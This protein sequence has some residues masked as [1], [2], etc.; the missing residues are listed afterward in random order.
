MLT[1]ILR[2]FFGERQP[3]K[4]SGLWY[5]QLMKYQGRG[6]PPTLDNKR[7]QLF[8]SREALLHDTIEKVGGTVGCLTPHDPANP[9]DE[10][11]YN[12]YDDEEWHDWQYFW[13]KRYTDDDE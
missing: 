9:P 6:I 11:L 3:R 12:W 4:K 5:V 13:I 8:T 2:W 10:T 1:R 7:G